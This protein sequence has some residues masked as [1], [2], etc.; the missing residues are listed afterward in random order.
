[1]ISVANHLMIIPIWDFSDDLRKPGNGE[2]IIS[3]NDCLLLNTQHMKNCIRIAV[4]TTLKFG[5]NQN[6][7][8]CKT[9]PGSP[10]G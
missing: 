8:S 5:L 3:H 2:I 9:F 6:P 1:M 4:H 7:L 10:I